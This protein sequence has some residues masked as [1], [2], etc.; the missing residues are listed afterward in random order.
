MPTAKSNRHRD[1]FDVSHLVAESA[2]RQVLAGVLDILDR[3]LPAT[4]E[5]VSSLSV[6]MFN[7]EGTG[8]VFKA[9]RD[10]LASVA[11]PTVADVLTALRGGGNE[12]GTP[13]YTLLVDLVADRI[14]TGP[15]A[16]RLARQAAV[17]IREV[18]ER[19]QVIEAAALVVQT[20]GKPEDIGALIRHLERVRAASDTAAGSRPL[21]LIDCLDAWAKH[22][23]TPV[24]AL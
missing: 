4:R 16:A 7:G 19:R 2:E 14:G 3:D 23:R 11:E 18:H 10:V 5:I 6:E 8:D 21:T 15:Q 12:H 22:E 9:T 20:G 17:E 13:A 1:P 24:E